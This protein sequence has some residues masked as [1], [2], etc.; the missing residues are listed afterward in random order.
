MTPAYEDWWPL[1]TIAEKIGAD[2]KMLAHW[3]GKR[4]NNGFPEPKRLMGKYKVFD[5]AEVQE[6]FILYQRVTAN[7]QNAQRLQG[8]R[9]QDD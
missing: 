4:K 7:M 1:V 8:K 3:E 2:P 9:P 5:I 6:W